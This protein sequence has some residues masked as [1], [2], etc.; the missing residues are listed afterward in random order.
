[1]EHHSLLLCSQSCHRNRCINRMMGWVVLAVAWPTMMT[2]MALVKQEKRSGRSS[3]RE[4]NHQHV[5]SKTL[6]WTRCRNALVCVWIQEIICD[7]RGCGSVVGCQCPIGNAENMTDGNPFVPYM[8]W[9]YHNYKCI[10]SL[11][12]NHLLESHQPNCVMLGCFIWSPE[13]VAVWGVTSAKNV[14]FVWI[15]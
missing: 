10:Y 3:K 4:E 7:L 12:E 14:C 11:F 1:M 6:R 9:V 15:L 13:L 8:H 5:E 2:L